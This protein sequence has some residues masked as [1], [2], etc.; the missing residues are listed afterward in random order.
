MNGA[1][2]RKKR[3]WKNRII[4]QKSADETNGASG[5]RG[6]SN[7]S[8]SRARC[9]NPGGCP[10]ADAHTA[11]GGTQGPTL[12]SDRDARAR[13]EGLISTAG[14]QDIASFRDGPLETGRR[15]WAWRTPLALGAAAYAGA[16]TRDCQTEVLGCLRVASLRKTS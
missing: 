13:A 15:A 8:A 11:D 4:L 6:I 9:L 5:Q 10:R 12:Q 16:F 3:G 1:E 2:R 14:W 7:A